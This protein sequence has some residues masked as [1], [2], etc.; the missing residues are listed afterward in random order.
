MAQWVLHQNGKIVPIE[1]LWRLIQ[2][3]LSPTNVVERT[4]REAFD[5]EIKWSLGN[6]L[7]VTPKPIVEAHDPN[8][9]Y[10]F[11]EEFDEGLPDYVFPVANAVNSTGK[12]INQQPMADLLINAEVLLDHGETQ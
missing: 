10:D 8:N 1:N 9:D 12:P 5:A 2:E 7:A 6:S 3:E 11:E 4:K